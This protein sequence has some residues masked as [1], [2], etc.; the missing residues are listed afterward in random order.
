MNLSETEAAIEIAFIEDIPVC[1]WGDPGAG[2]SSIVAALALKED[3][4]MLD[5]RLGQIDSVDLRGGLDIAFDE[6]IQ[7]KVTKW[8]PPGMFPYDMNSTGILNLDEINHADEATQKA[9]FQL[10]QDRRIGDYVLPPGWRIIAAGNP[11]TDRLI[12]ALNNRFLHLYVIPEV[13]DWIVWANKNQV[14]PDII[15]FLMAKPDRLLTMPD[16]ALLE[17]EA[18]PTPRQWVNAS[19][20]HKKYQTSPAYRDVMEGT[21]GKAAIVE[22]I[23]HLNMIGKLPTFAE[24]IANPTGYDF[25]TSPSKVAALCF[26][27]MNGVDRSSIDPV[28][29]YIVTIPPEFQVL[30]ISLLNDSKNALMGTSPVTNWLINNP[31]IAF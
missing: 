25:N 31:A 2:K 17:N 5:L 19:K 15:S 30:S 22:F 6:A 4:P 10:I 26:I 1:M 13:R 12:D 27:A 23:G 8:C 21:V 3:V 18:Y 24:L 16:G 28:M 9:A 11:G 14:S 20:I 29:Q 7:R